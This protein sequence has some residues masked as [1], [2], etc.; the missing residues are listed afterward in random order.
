[1]KSNKKLFL[2]LIFLH[3][4]I[5]EVAVGKTIEGVRLVMKV[6]ELTSIDPA[7][8]LAVI[9]T[10]SNFMVHARSHKGAEGLMQLMPGT[11]RIVG[12]TN[13]YDPEQN[14]RGGTLYLR[15]MLIRFGRVRTALMAYN[16]G[17]TRVA[18]GDIPASSYDYADK[19]LRYYW[20]YKKQLDKHYYAGRSEQ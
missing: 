19:V 7:L 8:I 5:S 6:S 20:I 2:L 1:M 13:P 15:K 17:P 10:E 12:V 16:A 18:R 14:I 11:Q 9:R 3:I 4:W